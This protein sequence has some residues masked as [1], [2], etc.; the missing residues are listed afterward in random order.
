MLERLPTT[1]PV[2]ALS[3]TSEFESPIPVGVSLILFTVMV[4]DFSKYA[5]FWSVVRIRTYF[6]PGELKTV[7]VRSCVP[8]IV[9]LLLFVDP[10]PDTREYVNVAESRSAVERLPTSELL[11]CFSLTEVFVSEMFVGG[12]FDSV[13][14]IVKTLS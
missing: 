13:S 4:N 5:P 10:D 12:R 2:G 8:E 11:A 3:E 14:V 6:S 9:K 1:V 7:F